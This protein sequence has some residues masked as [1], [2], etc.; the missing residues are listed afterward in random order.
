MTPIAD[1][2]VRA[3]LVADV[4]IRAEAWR[5]QEAETDVESERR[6]CRK[7]TAVLLQLASDVEDAA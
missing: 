5:A 2:I 4:R 7:A 6:Q 1:P 3:Q